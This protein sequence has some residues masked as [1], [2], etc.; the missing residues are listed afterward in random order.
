MLASEQLSS[1]DAG[2]ATKEMATAVNDNFF[3]E[4]A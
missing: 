2:K 3:F 4:H 1:N